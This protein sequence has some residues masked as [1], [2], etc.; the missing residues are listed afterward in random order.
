M[1]FFSILILISCLGHIAFIYFPLA[2]W[3]LMS[4]VNAYTMRLSRDFTYFFYHS[5]HCK[6]IMKDKLKPRD[7]EN[8]PPPDFKK[9]KVALWLSAI[10]SGLVTLVMI[11]AVIALF[12]ENLGGIGIAL[13]LLALRGFQAFY[14]YRTLRGIKFVSTYQDVEPD[15]VF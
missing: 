2:V 8:D 11:V 13:G 1:C 14:I 5:G 4:L 15:I 10:L 7:L 9:L 12:H 3:L 6:K